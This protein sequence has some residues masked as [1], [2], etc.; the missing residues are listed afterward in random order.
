MQCQ[1]FLLYSKHHHK[2]RNQKK[3]VYHFFF[4]VP[5][6]NDTWMIP[7]V[8]EIVWNLVICGDEI[9]II[10]M[11]S[12]YLSVLQKV[13][14]SV[15]SLILILIKLLKTFL[16]TRRLSCLLYDLLSV[17]LLHLSFY[18]SKSFGFLKHSTSDRSMS[19]NSFI[20]SCFK[21]IRLNI[22]VLRSHLNNTIFNVKQTPDYKCSVSI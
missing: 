2:L 20:K 1:E 14:L 17:S 16:L 12:I 9:S 15:M 3:N 10:T 5:Y 19:L 18:S 11:I 21:S 4:L 8:T 7:K 13:L 6:L 22:V